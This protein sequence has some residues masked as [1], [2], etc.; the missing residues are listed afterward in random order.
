MRPFLGRIFYLTKGDEKRIR[1]TPQMKRDYKMK[2][3]ASR[4]RYTVHGPM[5][6]GRYRVRDERTCAQ[7]D[8]DSLNEAIEFAREKNNGM[9]GL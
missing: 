8:F 7:Y 4:K 5:I 1:I 2:Q 9:K 6:N 3:S